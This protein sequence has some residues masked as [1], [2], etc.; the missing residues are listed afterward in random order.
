MEQLHRIG[1]RF[2]GTLDLIG[3]RDRLLSQRLK[4]LEAAGITERTVVPTAL[5]MFA[6][7]LA[8]QHSWAAAR[9]AEWE[10]A[11]D[12]DCV[13]RFA[14]AVARAPQAVAGPQLLVPLWKAACSISDVFPQA[15]LWLGATRVAVPRVIGRLRRDGR[16]F[17]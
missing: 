2:K 8:S 14:R 11:G 3:R 7:W 10:A 4:E 17:R 6:D 1:P 15:G 12:G 5:V 16:R 9:L 13:A